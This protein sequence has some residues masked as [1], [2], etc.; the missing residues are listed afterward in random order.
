MVIQPQFSGLSERL[1]AHERAMKFTILC[2]GRL[3]RDAE[4]TIFERYLERLSQIGGQCGLGEAA[5]IE[6]PESRA[7]MPQERK[8]TEAEAL[9]MLCTRFC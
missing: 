7:S 2:V 1:S 6:L 9:R 3:K 5:L 8:A 4:Q